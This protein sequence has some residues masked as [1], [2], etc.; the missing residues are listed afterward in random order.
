M[1]KQ[2]V[3]NHSGKTRPK[4]AVDVSDFVR[5]AQLMQRCTL[6]PRIFNDL[7]SD[8]VHVSATHSLL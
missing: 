7:S 5:F 2:E 1:T 3:T 8:P 6:Q 4:G